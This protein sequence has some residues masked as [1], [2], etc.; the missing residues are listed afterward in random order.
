MYKA[1]R[2][3]LAVDIPEDVE[4]VKKSLQKYWFL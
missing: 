4:L 2:S 1:S 3:S